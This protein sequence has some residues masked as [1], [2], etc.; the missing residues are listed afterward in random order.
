MFMVGVYL[1][2]VTA[3]QETR[4]VN[5]AGVS[6]QSRGE[7]HDSLLRN[8]RELSAA[9]CLGPFIQLLSGL[10]RS[11]QVPYS[12][13]CMACSARSSMLTPH[14]ER[15]CIVHDRPSPCASGSLAMDQLFFF[16]VLVLLF[17]LVH[18]QPAPFHCAM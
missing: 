14:S 11:G 13:S 5:T 3:P 16:C 15:C 2:I 7:R 9:L 18:V 12:H 6:S 10:M 4:D 1:W 17:A 8:A